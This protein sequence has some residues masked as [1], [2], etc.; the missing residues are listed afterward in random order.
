MV[1]AEAAQGDL[2]GLNIAHK[3]N[4]AIRDGQRVIVV[5]DEARYAQ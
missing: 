4:K 1:A 5:P 2:V 3:E